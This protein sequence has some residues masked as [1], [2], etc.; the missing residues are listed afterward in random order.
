M[1]VGSRTNKTR[2]FVNNNQGTSTIVPA[3]TDNRPD[4]DKVEQVLNVALI[5]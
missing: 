4:W 1:H 5:V 3:I 2:D